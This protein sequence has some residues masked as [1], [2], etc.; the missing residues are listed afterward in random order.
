LLFFVV[1][2]SVPYE[3]RGERA[4]WRQQAEQR[5]EEV[6]K[7][8]FTVVVQEHEGTPVEG[9]QVNLKM[10]RHAFAF[11]AAVT[12]K[13]MTADD[14]D[15]IRYR[16]AVSKLYNKVVLENDLKWQQWESA[17]GS[18]PGS[19]HLGPQTFAALEW[20]KSN[21]IPVRGH[22]VSWGPVEKFESYLKHRDAPEEFRQELFAHIREKVPG[23]GELVGEWDVVN[24]P[25]GWRHTLTLGELFGQEVYVDIA[26]LARKLNPEARLYINE[27]GIL[28][29]KKSSR[30]QRIN[31]EKL[32]QHLI[33]RG[34]PLDGVGFM[35]HFDHD[36][37]TSPAEILRIL[38]RFASLGLPLQITE[39]DVRFG[40]KGMPYNFSEAEL[41]L[42]ADYTRDF[43]TAVFS[44]PAV[45]GVVMWGFWE[46]QHYNPSAALYRKD[47]TVKPNGRVWEE[48]VFKEWWTDERGQTGED[49]LFAVGG[50]LGDYEIEV[51]HAGRKVTVPARL[52][53]GGTL[54]RI[55]LH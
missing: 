25:L 3:G 7:A 35:G 38:D 37:L 11:G 27:G 52:E 28:P 29:S 44:H 43:M 41:Q 34:A 9:A 22:Y 31:Y 8:T 45:E 15:S 23:V 36:S 49:G 16:E 55:V 26:K 10:V 24:H 21:K 47:W 20:L 14:P 46:G 48:L 40:K 54:V 1:P 4:E 13:R 18:A 19:V 42:Q 2:E 33:D 5:I 32:I 12:A 53:R 50:F 6:R 17:K 30:E 51:E 39:F